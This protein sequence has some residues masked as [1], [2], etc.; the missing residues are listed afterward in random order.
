[1]IAM[2]ILRTRQPPGDGMQTIDSALILK[3]HRAPAFTL[4]ANV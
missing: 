4:Y 1:V 2:Q 3:R